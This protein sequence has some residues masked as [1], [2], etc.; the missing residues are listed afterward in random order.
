MA[1]TLELETL[2]FEIL[3]SFQ[4]YPIT[5]KVCFVKE[6]ANYIKYLHM[7]LTWFTYVLTGVIAH[8]TL[9]SPSFYCESTTIGMPHFHGENSAKFRVWCAMA[10]WQ[11]FAPVYTAHA[12]MLMLGQAR[13]LQSIKHIDACCIHGETNVT[14]WHGS[15]QS[16]RDDHAHNIAWVYTYDSRLEHIPTLQGQELSSLNRGN[17]VAMRVHHTKCTI[18]HTHASIYIYIYMCIHHAQ[19]YHTAGK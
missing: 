5:S 8:R 9:S 14:W 7:F 19:C 11:G 1:L 15:K 10:H 12:N 18:T 13:A 17:Y 4:N 16:Y 2:F 3:N 6:L